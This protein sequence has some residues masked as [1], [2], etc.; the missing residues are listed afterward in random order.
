MSL[1]VSPR[2]PHRR[3]PSRR[4]LLLLLV[5]AFVTVASLLAALLIRFEGDI[6]TR[7]REALPIVL[8]P[9]ILARILLL[10]G[11]GLYHVQWRYAGIRDLL[12]LAASSAA[13]SLLFTAL[14]VFLQLGGYSQPMPRSVIVIDF[15]VF[16]APSRRRR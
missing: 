14:S 11:L 13:A 8:G 16:S 4:I 7:F 5:D 12:R 9:L 1:P 10:Y 15:L 2:R 3:F 6:E